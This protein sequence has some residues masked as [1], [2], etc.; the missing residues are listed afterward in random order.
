VT[1][2]R[3]I[4]PLNSAGAISKLNIVFKVDK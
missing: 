1:R 3:K 2:N 4:K